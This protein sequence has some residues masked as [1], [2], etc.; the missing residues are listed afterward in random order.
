[1]HRGQDLLGDV[2]GLDER[3]EGERGLALRAENAAP[4]PDLRPPCPL[5]AEKPEPAG[6]WID[7]RKHRHV[8]APG[9]FAVLEG[10]QGPVRHAHA[11][12]SSAM[13]VVPTAHPRVA[14]NA[15]ASA[16]G[17]DSAEA[18]HPRGGGPR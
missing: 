11:I 6:D 1:V 3:D 18:A 12:A 7:S 17:G 2:P 15:H 13:V 10:A 4:H 16:P 9:P 14:K 5:P 8:D